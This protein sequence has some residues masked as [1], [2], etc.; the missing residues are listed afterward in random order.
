MTNWDER[1][2][3]F[4]SEAAAQERNAAAQAAARAADAAKVGQEKQKLTDEKWSQFLDLTRWAIA[5]YKSANQQ[6]LPIYADG[7]PRYVKRIFQNP[8]KVFPPRFRV[9]AAHPLY[10]FQI[11]TEMGGYSSG[12]EHIWLVTLDDTILYLV[13]PYSLTFGCRIDAD[14]NREHG[15]G[16][17][18]WTSTEVAFRYSG[19]DPEKSAT[20]FLAKAQEF[21]RSSFPGDR[22]KSDEFFD[23]IIKYVGKRT[24]Q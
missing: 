7:P 4:Q 19:E 15:A 6:P 13:E 12:Y 1:L 17:W 23:S 18:T 2:A 24:N 21:A 20:S 8:R 14:W 3:K 16:Q 10:E 11:G 5:Q 9:G 22:I